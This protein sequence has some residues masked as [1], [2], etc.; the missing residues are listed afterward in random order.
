VDLSLETDTDANGIQRYCYLYAGKTEAPTLRMHPG[1][2]LTLRLKN[3]LP[4]STGGHVHNM[5]PGPV[6]G[7][8]G[9]ITANT[10][11]LHFHGM[12]VPPTCHADDVLYTLIQP[13]DPPFEYKV[14]IPL[15]EP[16]GLYWYHPHPHGF[17]EAQVLAAPPER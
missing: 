4:K 15:N 14:Q 11:N 12:N 2:W 16:P 17:S 9:P 10:S 3:A 7:S 13:N 1:D 5:P 8:P 6:C